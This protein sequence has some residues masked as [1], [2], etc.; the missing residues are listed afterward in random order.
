MVTEISWQKVL[1]YRTGADVPF[2]QPVCGVSE[3][4]ASAER[5]LYS[6]MRCLSH[7]LGGLSNGGWLG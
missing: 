2:L 1:H 7:S 4:L 5:P 6:N 3:T